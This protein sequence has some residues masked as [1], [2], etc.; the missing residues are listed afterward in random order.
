MAYN[1]FKRYVWLIDLLNNFDGVTF[2][3]IDDAWRDE[4]DMNPD[5]DPLPQRTFY[6]HIKAIKC[7]FNIEIKRSSKDGRYRVTLDDG[8]GFGKMQRSLMSMLSLS[9]AIDRYSGLSGRILYEED[10]YVCPEWI[11]R[12]IY[13]MNHSKM[14]RMEYR[15]YGDGKSSLRTLAPYCLKM[16]KRRWYLLAKDGRSLKVFALDDRTIGVEELDEGFGLPEDFDAE[17]YFKNVFGIR[18]SPP[19]RVVLKAYGHEVDY[20]RST[21][22]HPSQKEEESG[23]G[24]SIF[25]LFVGINA[26]E[27]Y[28]EIL[29]HGNRLEVLEPKTL[30][31]D[32]A[33]IIDVMRDRYA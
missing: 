8:S 9:G 20:L 3:D 7:V 18:L 2:D 30:R 10:P 22:L 19:K 12:I 14:I 11:K 23:D 28:Q 5:G 16:F 27:F 33:D 25:S 17:V 31:E 4:P 29:S 1:D 24:F 13:A 32:I 21:P 6:N 15:K 26:W